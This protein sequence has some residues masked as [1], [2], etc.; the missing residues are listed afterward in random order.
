LKR[1]EERFSWAV[2]H[3]HQWIDWVVEKYI[4]IIQAENMIMNDDIIIAIVD[5][6]E[7]N[8]C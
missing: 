5:D 7:G 3:A 2:Y 1:Q 6:W 4:V 8:E